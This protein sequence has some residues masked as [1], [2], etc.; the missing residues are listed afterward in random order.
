MIDSSSSSSTTTRLFHDISDFNNLSDYLA[1]LCSILFVESSIIYIAFENSRNNTAFLSSKQ[2]TKWYKRYRFAAVLADVMIVFL[3]IVAAR[4]VYPWFFSS[5][6]VVGFLLVAVVIQVLHDVFFALFVKIIPTGWNHMLDF[7]KDYIQEAGVM[8]IF[9]DS[10]M[11]I[12]SC[13]LASYYAGFSFNVNIVNLLCT[14]Y[15]VPYVLYMR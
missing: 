10:V 2:L 3:V 12:C 9:S 1:I 5:F 4:F 7:F 15:F 6:H 14:L 11:M 8:E 13:L